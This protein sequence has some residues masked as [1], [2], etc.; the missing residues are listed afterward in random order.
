MFFGSSVA[1]LAEVG[2]LIPHRADLR[3]QP[4]ATVSELFLIFLFEIR[5]FFQSELIMIP[6]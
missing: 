2:K 1:N 4:A 3:P 6:K 5:L